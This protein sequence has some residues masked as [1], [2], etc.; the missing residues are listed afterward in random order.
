MR[1]KILIALSVL[2]AVIVVFLIVVAVQPS[3][4]RIER[5]TTVSAPPEIVFEQVNDFHNWND[6]SPW[7]KLDPEAKNSFEGLE[8][9]KGAMFAWSG[10]DKVGEGRMTILDGRP[11]ELVRIKLDFIKPFEDTATAEFTFR[12]E[13]EQTVVTWTM[14]GRK[15]F[16]GKAICMFM[17]MDKMLGGEFEKGLASLKAV[18]EEKQSQANAEQK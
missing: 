9:G 12:P 16:I 6:W 1:K 3:D 10:N 15:N 8:S 17:N 2:A 13:G 18:A 14:F 11:G 7:A 5:S 4:Y